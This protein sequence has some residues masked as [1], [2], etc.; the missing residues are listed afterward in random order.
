MS[1]QRTKSYSP[2]EDFL[3]PLTPNM[4]ITGRNYCS[5]TTNNHSEFDED[6]RVRSNFIQDLEASWWYQYKSQCFASLVPTRKWL[7]AKRNLCPGDVV[8]IQYAS[9]TVPGTYRL[10]R[11]K[12]VQEDSDGLVRTCTVVYV[13]CKGDIKKKA[14][15]KEICL[16]VQRIVLI[17]PVEEQ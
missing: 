2:D 16:P 11:I 13:L 17:L 8:L 1:A 7:E 14:V 9:K 6:V 15:F 12:S 3:S 4:L 5:P 10:G